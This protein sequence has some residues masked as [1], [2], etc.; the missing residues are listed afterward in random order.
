MKSSNN[1]Q[2]DQHL[3]DNMNN[4]KK[5]PS[6]ESDVSPEIK[7]LL[8]KKKSESDSQ[9]EKPINNEKISLPFIMRTTIMNGHT[10]TIEGLPTCSETEEKKHTKFK[11]GLSVKIYRYPTMEIQS[12]NMQAAL[13]NS[14][15][16][17]EKITPET[18]PE[19]NC[20]INQQLLSIKEYEEEDE[21]NK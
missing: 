10:N 15:K 5:N 9:Q 4:V 12:P 21:K 20:N 13:E 16:L 1:I 6:I 7:F 11:K 17:E 14:L 8:L 2:E 18:L 19:P 3:I